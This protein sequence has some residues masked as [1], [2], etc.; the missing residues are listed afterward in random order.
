M[1]NDPKALCPK[2]HSREFKPW[3]DLDRDEKIA[4]E[5]RPNSA[6]F[7]PN[8]RKKHRICTRCWFERDDLGPVLT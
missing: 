7:T 8:Q 1:H 2:C 4:A 5:S 3:S 6:K